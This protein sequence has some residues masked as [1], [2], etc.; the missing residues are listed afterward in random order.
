[1]Y[2]PEVPELQFGGIGDKKQEHLAYYN[3]II[4][5]IHHKK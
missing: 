5:K 4:K 3:I 2:M 1:M